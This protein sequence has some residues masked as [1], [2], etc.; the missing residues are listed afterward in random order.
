MKKKATATAL[1]AASLTGL[2]ACSG[3]GGFPESSTSEEAPASGIDYTEIYEPHEMAL[4]ALDKFKAEENYCAVAV[5]SSKAAGIVDQGIYALHIKDGDK[6]FEESVSS[7]IVNIYDRMWEEGDTTK[8]RWG[9]S[10]DYSS[11]EEKTMS[12]D[13]YTSLM[14]RKVSDLSSYTISEDT[15]LKDVTK[16]GRRVTSV[17]KTGTNYIVEL[18]LDPETAVENY[19]TQMKTIS[20]LA[21]R[22]SFEYCHLT[23]VLDETLHI[24]SSTSYEKY[25]AKINWLI[26]SDCEGKLETK[27]QWGKKTLIPEFESTSDYYDNFDSFVTGEV[28]E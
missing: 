24:L 12:N 16:S 26:S 27:Y 18:E 28:S 15:I 17:R 20:S 7:G 1:L 2:S 8:T 5:G 9:D 4:M 3:N 25:H 11:M 19:K 13:E 23:F 6:F 14:G 10:S 21:E 22:P